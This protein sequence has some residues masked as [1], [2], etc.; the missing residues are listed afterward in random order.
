MASYEWT[1]SEGLKK[2]AE[3]ELGETPS[4]R[5]SALQKLRER[6]D[7]KKG[8]VFNTD[9][10]FLIRFLRARKFE[11]DRA[12]KSIVKYYELHVKHP[13]F[14]EKYHPTGIK[15]VL[16]DGYPYVLESTDKEGRH[17]VAMKT[18]HWDPRLYPITDIALAL[19][20]VIDQLVEDEA[21]QINGVILLFDLEGVNLSQVTC[22]TPSVA[23]KLTSIFQNCVPVR[24]QGIHFINESLL[25]DGAF[26]IIK[27]FM[28][29]KIRKRVRL[30]GQNMETLHEYLSPSILPDTF[31]G[32]ITN[33]DSLPW[34]Q[35]FLERDL[36]W[37]PSHE[38]GVLKKKNKGKK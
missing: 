13:D 16:D 8:I 20:M 31:G 22:L 12:F 35:A 26:T 4:V 32:D 27:P 33:Y 14:F 21:A 7:E 38:E 3:L 37:Q 11:V 5:E 19:F 17:I 18:G 9:S 29:E 10:R 15:H 6:M 1:M 25:F 23:R 34:R 2:K 24:V 28:Q 30:H 36:R